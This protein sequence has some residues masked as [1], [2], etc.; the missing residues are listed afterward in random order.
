MIVAARCP[1]A[2]EQEICDPLGL[3]G[4]A[5]QNIANPGEGV[6]A[7][8]NCNNDGDMVRCWKRYCPEGK[9]FNAKRG[10]CRPQEGNQEEEQSEEDKPEGDQTSEYRHC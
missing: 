7:Y 5:D 3:T 9:I 6:G 2:T 8:Y 1:L 4:G 10:R